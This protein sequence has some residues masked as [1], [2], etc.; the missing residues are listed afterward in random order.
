VL[1][2]CRSEANL[3]EAG[4]DPVHRV[5]EGY[6]PKH[7]HETLDSPC[8]GPGFTCRAIALAT[9][10][11]LPYVRRCQLSFCNALVSIKSVYMDSL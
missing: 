6:P 3:P 2:A 9:A 11:A 7:H 10:D 8:V 1:F 4:R 5:A